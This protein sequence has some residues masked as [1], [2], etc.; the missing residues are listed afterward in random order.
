MLKHLVAALIHIVVTK[1]KM[2]CLKRTFSAK[3]TCGHVMLH[4]SYFRRFM[5]QSALL[6]ACHKVASGL[7]RWPGYASQS[8]PLFRENHSAIDKNFERIISFNI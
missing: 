7:I 2:R 8:R 4:K 5:L 3:K 1:S 6:H